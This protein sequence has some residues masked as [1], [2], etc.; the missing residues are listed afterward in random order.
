[1]NEANPPFQYREDSS[2]SGTLTV[3]VATSVLTFVFES[4]SDHCDSRFSLGLIP[5][6]IGKSVDFPRV[7]ELAERLWSMNQTRVA[8]HSEA[9]K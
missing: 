7:G 6:S 9:G 4:D 8:A 3:I 1:M 2:V 5:D